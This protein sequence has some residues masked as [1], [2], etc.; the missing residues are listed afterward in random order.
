[1]DEALRVEG[2]DALAA[3][4]AGV[5]AAGP[6]VA[7][8]EALF[9]A[10]SVCVV[11]ASRDP[12]KLA[13]RALAHLLA[14]GYPGRVYAVNPRHAE[15]GGV[16]CVPTV[17]DLPEPVD[18]ALVGVPAAGVPE[19][20]EACG[21][22]GVRSA[23]VI[24]AGFEEQAGGRPRAEALR[25]AA[26]R[27]GLAVI[28]PNSEGV[29]SVGRRLVLSFGSAAR[30]QRLVHG[31]VAVVSQ[32]GAVGAGVVRLLQDGCGSDHFVSVGNETVLS[33][34]DVLEYLVER[35][36]LR[37]VALFVEALA[38]GER[39]LRCAARARARGV[40]L[41]VLKAGSSRLGRAAT[42]SHT[43]KLSS[44]E[45]VYRDILR[46]AG[47]LQ[48]EGLVELAEAC[49][50]LVALPGPRRVGRPGAG[51]AVLS[52]PGGT[53]ALTADLAERAA[54][55]LAAFDEATV[56]ALAGCLPPFGYP[57]NPTDVTGEALT[58][59]GLLDRALEAVAADPGVEA[60][61]LQ[62]GNGGLAEARAR[63]EALGALAGRTGV[64]VVVS[65]L[66]DVIPAGEQATLGAPG[67][68]AVRDPGAAVRTLAWIY[69]R[70]EFAGRAG[71][72]PAVPGPAPAPCPWPGTWPEQ[73][74]CLADAGIAVPPWV[75]LA[76]GEA[77]VDR[78]RELAFPVAVKAS[79]ERAAHRTEQGLVALDVPD[80][81]GV[82]RVVAAWR[83]RPGLE[84][85]P[86]LV[87]EMVSDG[88]EVL[89]GVTRD[90][91]FGPVLTVGAGGRLAEL[92]ED[93]AHLCL[94]AGRADVH[95]AL[96]GL[97]LGRVLAG[98]RGRP[99][100]DVEALVDAALGLARLH[101]ALG[102][103]CRE[104]EVNPLLVRA[105]GAV[106]LDLWLA[107]TDDERA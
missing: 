96:A 2:E 8:L 58:V 100:A 6:P 88:V 22:R 23:V 27:H 107:G 85:A 68:L 39:L 53:R 42:A 38:G 47:I 92:L 37:V 21:R 57:R 45:G 52:V 55:P 41:V 9:G 28:G 83:R 90:P 86:C 18:A 93:V 105:C 97:R 51:V 46:Q 54:V 36:D 31:P 10:R 11:G 30:R 69:A 81:G 63:R 26:A 87:Q 70:R 65:L 19:V 84:G 60:L 94:P 75:L 17:A 15:V 4:A 16:P 40:Q 64:P 24:S 1:V 104:L 7:G 20:I 99:P 35:E 66:G 77:A 13:S 74:A 56:E 82:D 49:H 91:D 33:A 106:A 44:P 59:P 98:V 50:A 62:L 72:A 102:P 43:G 95:R 79:P 78:C 14:H 76:P 5:P 73:A 12:R 32:S 80:A 25:R 89:V 48:V 61:V 29:W 101:A 103:R 34:L 67:V 71:P 3:R